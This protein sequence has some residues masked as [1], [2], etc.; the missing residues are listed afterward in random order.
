WSTVANESRNRAFVN[1]GG[2]RGERHHNPPT[3]STAAAWPRAASGSGR[4]P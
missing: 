1:P 2:R 4:P 3:P